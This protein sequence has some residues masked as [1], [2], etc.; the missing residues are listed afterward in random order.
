MRDVCEVFS[1]IYYFL[2]VAITVLNNYAAFCASFGFFT[3]LIL[4]PNIF[5]RGYK[6]NEDFIK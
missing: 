2:N 6:L 3:Y 1:V 5:I 4:I